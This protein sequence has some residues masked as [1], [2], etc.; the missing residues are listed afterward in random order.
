MVKNKKQEYVSKSH[1]YKKQPIYSMRT[2]ISR[3]YFHFLQ[4]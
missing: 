2:Y 1:V 4:I 3:L